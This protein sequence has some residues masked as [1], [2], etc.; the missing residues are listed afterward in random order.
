MGK[1]QHATPLALPYLIFIYIHI[2]YIFGFRGFVCQP[3][4]YNT[5]CGFWTNSSSIRHLWG[6]RE[7]DATQILDLQHCLQFCESSPSYYTHWIFFCTYCM[8]W[9]WS[10]Q[11]CAFCFPGFSILLVFLVFFFFK[12][13]KENWTLRC[14]FNFFI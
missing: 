12:K 1:S 7:I 2:I 3:P 11:I 4:T 6:G 13:K 9:C 5:G 10:V 14:D 8:F